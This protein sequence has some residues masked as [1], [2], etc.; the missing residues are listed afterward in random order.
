[1]IP[2]SKSTMATTPAAYSAFSAVVTLRGGAEVSST[3]GK[4]RQYGFAALGGHYRGSIDGVARG[5][6]EAPDTWHLIE[7]KTVNARGFARLQ[8]GLRVANP[9]HYAQVQAYLYE[10]DIE[11]AMYIAVCKDNDR[12]Y[13]ERIKRDERT[14]AGLRRRALEVIRADEPPRKF[15]DGPDWK[16]QFECRFCPASE[17]CQEG[18]PAE[19]NCRTCLYSRPETAGDGGW[20]CTRPPT[21]QT[22]KGEVDEPAVPLDAPRM[23]V[24]CEH[25]LPLPE[26][27]PWAEEVTDSDDDWYAVRVRD[28][29][30][31]VAITGRAGFPVGYPDVI[32]GRE[33]GE[34]PPGVQ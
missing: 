13:T 12:V 29:G 6:P 17:V 16:S 25:Y 10:M 3:D 28:Y 34:K 26:L 1:M 14:G 11:W 4:G 21:D 22:G 20:V 2:P 15:A 30:H 27:V 9:K 18:R 23:A 32:G 31:E 7:D 24:G 19:V 33:I 8:K 5:L